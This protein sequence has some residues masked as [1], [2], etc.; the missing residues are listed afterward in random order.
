M[1]D[2]PIFERA[3]DE[4]NEDNRSRLN[5]FFGVFFRKFWKLITINLMFLL[6]NLPAIIISSLIS[7]FMVMMFIPEAPQATPDE[8]FTLMFVSGFPTAMFFMA[9][10][11]ITV[12]PAQAGLTYLMRCYAY[13]RPT[14]NWSDFKDKM[15]E[16]MKQGIL[17]SL[18][19][20][21]ILVFLIVDLYLYPLV[22]NGSTLFSI[23]NGLVI[24]VFLLYMMASLYI[25]PMMVT[26]KLRIRDLYKNAIL[27]ALARFIPNLAILILCFL[28]IIAPTI[29]VSLTSSVFILVL[30]YVI[31][32]TFGFTL[33]GLIINYLI[34]PVMD[35]YLNKKE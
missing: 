35:K 29:L 7:F 31:Y 8:L 10:P 11:I 9:I 2:E 32:F 19:N 3:P 25:Y 5:I 12:G 22:S 14:F 17:V 28:V 30:T 16:N 33:P 23:F 26:Y 1:A 13:E 18:I 27:F 4:K 20:L 34:N 6:F 24:V 15:K 21:F